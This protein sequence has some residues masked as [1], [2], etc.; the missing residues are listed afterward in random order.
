MYEMDPERIVNDFVLAINAH[1][2]EA[3]AGLMTEDHTFV[4]AYGESWQGRSNMQRA[5][6]GYFAWFPDYAIRVDE[7]FV[8][9]ETVVMLGAARGTYAVE[10]GLLPENRWEIP[11]AWKGVVRDGLV[12]YWQVYADN[13]PV[14]DI[15]DRESGEPEEG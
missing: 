12:S 10:G 5:W 14:R 9:G 13:K 6:K 8:Y 7:S 1:N 11:A 3:L 15:M 2:A 4:D